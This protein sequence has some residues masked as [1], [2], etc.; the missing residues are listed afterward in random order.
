MTKELAWP[1]RMMMIISCSIFIILTFLW[2]VTPAK[3]LIAGFILGE[4]ISI[5]NI[6]HLA[7]R[8]KL[9]GDR[10]AAGSQ[11]LVGIK[12]LTRILMVGFGII[13]VYRFPEWIDY[14]SFVLTLPFGY[15]LMVV[16]TSF[17]Y[18]KKSSIHQEEGRDVLG[19]DSEN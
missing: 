7:Y 4:L 2:F 6:F 18:I 8:V 3:P 15:I 19:T 1:V 5:Y 11:K 14:R 9:A 16:V 17:F 13:L 10:V 12:T